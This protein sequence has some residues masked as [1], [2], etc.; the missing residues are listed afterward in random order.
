M[1]PRS[2]ILHKSGRDDARDA[3]ISVSMTRAVCQTVVRFHC[4]TAPDWLGVAWYSQ[5]LVWYRPHGEQ[6]KLVRIWSQ[7][8]LSQYGS[9]MAL[10][11]PPWISSSPSTSTD[12]ENAQSARRRAAASALG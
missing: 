2:L 4:T 5:M 7:A 6:S 8:S 3:G 12:S 11:N 9:G 10:A 1:S